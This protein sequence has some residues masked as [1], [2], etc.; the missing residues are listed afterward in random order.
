MLM[1]TESDIA[2]LTLKY[3]TTLMRMIL[4]LL[5]TAICWSQDPLLKTWN[6]ANAISPLATSIL[7]LHY[8]KDKDVLVGPEIYSLGA[9]LVLTL[10]SNYE[11]REGTRRF[12]VLEGVGNMVLLGMMGVMSFWIS[13]YLILGPEHYL[14]FG[15]EM[16]TEGARGLWNIMIGVEYSSFMFVMTFALFYLNE[17]R[18]RVSSF[19][20]L[21]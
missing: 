2:I 15:G 14:V 18:K 19:L 12:R 3:Q 13:Q 5:T 20:C 4:Y 6:Y 7:A 17:W 21:V 9:I 11:G 8:H 10:L 16:I 1:C